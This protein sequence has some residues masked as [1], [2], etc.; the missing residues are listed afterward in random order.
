[1]SK[2]TIYYWGPTALA[3]M[4]G[5]GIGIYATL[6]QAGAEYEVKPPTEMPEAGSFAPPCIDIDGTIV[7]QT[8]AILT[9]LGEKYGLIGKS[10]AEKGRVLQAML[11]LNDIFGEHGKFVEDA[12]RKDK[13][14]SYLETKL[15]QNA[16]AGG[17]S[18]PWVAGTAEPTIA[19]FHGV[20]CFEW[21]VKKDIDFTGYPKVVEWWSAIK[22]WPAVKQLYDS[23]VDG[24]TM[25]PP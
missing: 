14:M 8:P 23:C 20:F 6:I 19:D 25:I 2:I 22:L 10:P 5:R 3:N 11:D 24:R 18:T 7:G 17:H 13:W 21:V 4:Y 16:E 12:S 9:L 15:N 1:M